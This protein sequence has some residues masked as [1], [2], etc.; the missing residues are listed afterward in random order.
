LTTEDPIFAEFEYLEEKHRTARAAAGVAIDRRN[1]SRWVALGHRRAGRRARAAS[2]Y[3]QGAVRNRDPGSLIRGLLAPL[4]ER[5]AG[6]LRTRTRGRSAEEPPE[7]LGE[8]D[9]LALYR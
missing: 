5:P 6:W 9:W 1:F 7:G 4:G 3:F 2:T 8:P